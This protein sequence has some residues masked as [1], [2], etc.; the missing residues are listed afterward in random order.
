MNCARAA[1]SRLSTRIHHIEQYSSFQYRD[2]M[3]SE[4]YIHSDRQRDEY[5]K[6]EMIHDIY[7]LNIVLLEFDCLQSFTNFLNFETLRDMSPE[8][9]MNKFIK[10][11]RR[12]KAHLRTIFSEVI[13]T[14][15]IKEFIKKLD[16]AA[17]INLFRDEICT[18]LNMI[19]I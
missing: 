9:R 3:T 18:K 2:E 5:R 12:L 14:C 4:I 11:A 13:T 8:D 1:F 10:K 15:F 16:N 17:L 6:Y 7:S 19:E